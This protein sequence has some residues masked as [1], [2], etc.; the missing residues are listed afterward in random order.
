MLH[1]TIFQPFN[2]L[3]VI[4]GRYFPEYDRTHYSYNYGTAIE[5]S[6][7]KFGKKA[8]TTQIV[9]IYEKRVFEFRG[10]L[11]NKS[12]QEIR[13]NQYRETLLFD[14][15]CVK[16]LPAIQFGYQNVFEYFALGSE[17]RDPDIQSL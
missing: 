14:V 1:Q 5:F 15:S 6:P 11:I 7:W 16:F 3:D 8:N 2:V 17:S 10:K 13:K 4:P 9:R 12:R